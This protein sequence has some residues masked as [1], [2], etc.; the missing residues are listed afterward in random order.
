MIPMC[1]YTLQETQKL[2][3]VHKVRKATLCHGENQSLNVVSMEI[4]GFISCMLVGCIEDILRFSGISA[5]SRLG[6]R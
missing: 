3:M 6:S 5:I 2:S 4:Q 1:R